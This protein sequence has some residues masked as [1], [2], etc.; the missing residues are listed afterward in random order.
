M[1]KHIKKI[2]NE[3][4]YRIAQ[5][6]TIVGLLGFLILPIIEP[7]ILVFYPLSFYLL[8]QVRKK[9]S[10]QSAKEQQERINLFRNIID[11]LFIK[12]LLPVNASEIDVLLKK[13]IGKFTIREFPTPELYL[14]IDLAQKLKKDVLDIDADK[15]TYEAQQIMD[16]LI[17]EITF[18]KNLAF[19]VEVCSLENVNSSCIL[20]MVMSHS[21]KRKTE[22]EVY[23]EED[24]DF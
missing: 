5:I 17:N 4:K 13:G 14:K 10:D 1:K 11:R 15:L 23:H 19:Q 7:D 8:V 6:C 20:K 12:N 3:V 2:W 22:A 24:A 16:S 9:E 21:P 18:P